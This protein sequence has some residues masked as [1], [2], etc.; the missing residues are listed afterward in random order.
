MRFLGYAYM[1]QIK[2]KGNFGMKERAL[3]RDFSRKKIFWEQKIQN[4]VR[5]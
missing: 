4:S 2:K 3:R 5:P 1:A